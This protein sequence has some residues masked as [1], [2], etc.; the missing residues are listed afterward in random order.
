[1]GNPMAGNPMASGMM[2]QQVGIVSRAPKTHS[3][4]YRQPYSS[5]RPPL[6]L[7]PFPTQYANMGYPSSMGSNPYGMSM[8][9]PMYDYGSSYSQLQ[10]NYGG[11]AGMSLFHQIPPAPATSVPEFLFQLTKML[12]D[13]NKEIIEW[14]NGKI[15]VHNP[16]KVRRPRAKG[17]Q[18]LRQMMIK[19][20]HRAASLRLNIAPPFPTTNLTLCCTSQLAQTVLHRY[21]RHSKYAR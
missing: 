7:T 8:G 15:A 21:F 11:M 14:V 12:T 19:R 5:P 3:R 4:H 2:N 6:P 18:R 9:Q 17:V 1:M 16:N 13:D 20:S 10:G